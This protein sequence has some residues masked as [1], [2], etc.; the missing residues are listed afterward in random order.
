MLICLDEEKEREREREIE[1]QR[2]KERE[3]EREREREHHGRN[4]IGRTGVHQWE[5]VWLPISQLFNHR[6]ECGCCRTKTEI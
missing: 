3:R 4:E 5:T 2:E 1:R 6:S